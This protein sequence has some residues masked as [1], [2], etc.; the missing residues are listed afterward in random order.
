M[1]DESRYDLLIVDEGQDLM[2]ETYLDVMDA[3]LVGG[4]A[5]GRWAVFFDPK[6]DLFDGMGIGGL[7]GLCAAAPA[8]FRLKTNCRNTAPVAVTTSLLS[9]VDAD[10]T[11][12]V[13]GPEVTELWYRDDSEQR[14]RLAAELSRLLSQRLKASD[15]VVLGS[16]RLADSCLAAG[17]KGVPYPIAELPI[18]GPRLVSAIGYASI[19]S[20]KGLESDAVIIAGIEDMESAWSLNQLY[21]AASRARAYL[22]VLMSESIRDQYEERARDFG[23]RLQGVQDA[24]EV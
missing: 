19:S 21:V 17:I 14:R 20:Y 8:Q 2:R 18:D 24:E 10:E 9:G 1:D 23:R 3:I 5:G 13:D 12:V 22:A 6:Q 7:S 4:L 11:L 16:R 15:I